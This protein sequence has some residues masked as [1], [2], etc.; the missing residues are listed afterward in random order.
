MEK[1]IVAF[2]E[3]LYALGYSRSKQQAFCMHVRV[4]IE[5]QRI[6]DIGVVSK[7]QLKEFYAY[8]F[9]CPSRTR[10]KNNHKHKGAVG[11]TEATI[12]HYVYSLQYFFNWL[13]RTQQIGINPISGIRFNRHKKNRRE[14]LSKEQIEALFSVARDMEETAILHLFYSCGLRRKEAELLDVRDVQLR[15]RLIYVRAGKGGKRRV[16][17]VTARV[18]DDLEN[19][20]I[21]YRITLRAVDGDAERAF[22]LNCRG[23][24]M[25]GC[26]YHAVLKKMVAR[27]AGVGTV[28]V[29]EDISLHHLRHSI[30]THLLQGGMGMEYV[31]DFLGHSSIDTTQVYARASME[32]L[33]SV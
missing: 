1:I 2:K 25:K 7:E 29:I 33:K 12:G 20:Y 21:N 16:I 14:A 28:I 13:E 6:E 8:L 18:A 23:G 4:F 11:L 3:H 15:Q 22:M 17:P 30:A 10:G 27:L 31:K 9:S 32:Q 24:R 5:Q 26:S 19:Y